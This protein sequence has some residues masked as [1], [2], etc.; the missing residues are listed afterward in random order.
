MAPN[1]TSF[2]NLQYLAES[3]GPSRQGQ[4][5]DVL[6][7]SFAWCDANEHAY[8]GQMKTQAA[9]HNKPDLIHAPADEL[10]ACFLLY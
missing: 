10:C 7:T 8:F 6:Y 5:L 2:H 1:L 4:D 3:F 9:H